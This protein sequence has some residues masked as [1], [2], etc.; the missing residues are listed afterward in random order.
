MKETMA[1]SKTFSGY[2]LD[3]SLHLLLLNSERQVCADLSCALCVGGVY[4][5]GRTCVW[6]PVRFAISVPSQD[7]HPKE[8]EV[9]LQR[10]DLQD[11]AHSQNPCRR[12]SWVPKQQDTPPSIDATKEGIP[13]RAPMPPPHTTTEFKSCLSMALADGWQSSLQSVGRSHSLAG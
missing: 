5:C 10:P 6:A 12:E 3:L 7:P 9:D 11:F 8:Q 2:D 1:I 13:I 4:V